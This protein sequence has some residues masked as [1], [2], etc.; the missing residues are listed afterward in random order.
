MWPGTSRPQPRAQVALTAEGVGGEYD[1][2]CDRA[3]SHGLISRRGFGLWPHPSVAEG[4]AARRSILR[5]PDL[6][7]ASGEDAV[8]VAQGPPRSPSSERPRAEVADRAAAVGVAPK[9]PEA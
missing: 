6:T 1:G 3:D 5:A 8:R 7:F 4:H 9:V 2:G